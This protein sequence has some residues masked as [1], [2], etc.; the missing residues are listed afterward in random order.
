M[1]VKG[2]SGNPGGR[3]K[4]ELGLKELAR[5]RTKE[6]LETLVEVMGDKESP[7]AARVTAACALLDRG[8]GKPTQTTEITGKDGGAIQTE[9]YSHE[10]LAKRVWFAVKNGT[11][12]N[13]GLVN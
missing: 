3:P 12:L 11:E 5:A 7:A 10:E 2:Q 13:P 4:D 8:Y 1:F 6:A 9:S